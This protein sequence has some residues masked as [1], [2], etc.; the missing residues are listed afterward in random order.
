MNILI[1]PAEGDSIE[2]ETWYK[3]DVQCH[4]GAKI[5][6]LDIEP[7]L[8]ISRGVDASIEKF[9]CNHHDSFEIHAQGGFGAYVAYRILCLFPNNIAKVFFIGGAPSD[10]MTSIARLF[11]KYLSRLWYFSR[12]PF[13]AD[14]PNPTRDEAIKMIKNSSTKTMRANPKYYC[15]Q[16]V[17]IGTWKLDDAWM[18]PNGCDAFFVPNGDTVRPKWWDNT[19]NNELAKASWKKHGVQSTEKPLNHFSFYSLMPSKSLFD[20]MDSVRTWFL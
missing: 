7:D 1:I 12:I 20:V 18:P 17:H 3:K 5:Y 10:S 13:F 6:V 11:H 19:Y 9:F 16:L 14:D 2:T 4:Y 8:N 15:A